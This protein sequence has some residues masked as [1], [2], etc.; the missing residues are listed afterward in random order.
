M[1]TCQWDVVRADTDRMRRISTRIGFHRRWEEATAQL[2]TTLFMTGDIPGAKRVFGELSASAGE[3]GDNQTQVWALVGMGQIRLVQGDIE[4][5]H[6]LLGAAEKLLAKGLTRAE[7]IYTL[8]PLALCCLRMGDDA[9][10]RRVAEACASWIRQGPPI[11]CYTI[12]AY[13]SAVATFWGL[14][15]NH[16]QDFELDDGFHGMVREL[17]KMS[18]LFPAAKAFSAIWQAVIKHER[19]KPAQALRLLAA[20]RAEAQRYG[21]PF[22]EA[23]AELGLAALTDNEGERRGHE[24]RARELTDRLGVRVVWPLPASAG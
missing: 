18:R 9:R 8:G 11:F 13:A 5:A 22:E 4:G 2:G 10:A 14:R 24:R 1:G 3:R 7:Q 16:P 12:F 17:K 21:Q 19:G 15:A 6:N 20:G 23:F